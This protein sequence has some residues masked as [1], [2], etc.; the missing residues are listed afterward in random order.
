MPWIAVAISRSALCT[1]SPVFRVGTGDGVGCLRRWIISEAV[2][3]RKSAMLT[4]GKGTY[5]GKNMTVSV[6]TSDLVSGMK[7]FTHL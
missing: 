1:G 3:W 7:H 6:M 5:C 2:C 4:V